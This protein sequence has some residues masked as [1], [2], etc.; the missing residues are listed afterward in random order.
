MGG[1][2]VAEVVFI[3]KVVVIVG[4]GVRRGEAAVL[5]SPGSGG[6]IIVDVIV[7]VVV[8]VVISV[9]VSRGEGAILVFVQNHVIVIVVVVSVGVSRGEG[10]VLVYVQDHVVIVIVGN[11]V[12]I[13]II[14]AVQQ[15]V[16]VVGGGVGLRGGIRGGIVNVDIEESQCGVHLGIAVE[17]SA[18]D[19]PAVHGGAHVLYRKSGGVITLNTS[20]GEHGPEILNRIGLAVGALEVPAE[21]AVSGCRG[22]EDRVIADEANFIGRVL[23]DEDSIAVCEGQGSDGENQNKNKYD[24]NQLF[25]FYLS[26]LDD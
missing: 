20:I 7:V 19:S 8:V 4:I 11:V 10:A 18:V 24:R 17:E 14:I 25:H 3:H 1:H 15:G 12:V 23:G 5:I 9:G 22:S 13:T 6:V 26:P 2:E 21:L 16:G